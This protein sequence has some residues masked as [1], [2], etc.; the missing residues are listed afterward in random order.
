MVGK[1]MNVKS[2]AV[3]VLLAGVAA[4]L[5]FKGDAWGPAVGITPAHREPAKSAAESQLDGLAPAAIKHVEVEY[6]SGESLVLDR[7]ANETGWKLPG[8][9]PLR[10]PEVEELINTLGS[11]RSRFHT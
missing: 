1:A 11:L 8:N 2:T 9:W 10:K 6:P 5:Y 3:L 4:L 7:A